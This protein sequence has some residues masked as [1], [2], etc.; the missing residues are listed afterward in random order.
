MEAQEKYF[1]FEKKNFS[2]TLCFVL[3]YISS[4]QFD[5]PPVPLP[6]KGLITTMQN[7]GFLERRTSSTVS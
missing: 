3:I 7:I 1:L 2:S 4:V 6:N 5:V